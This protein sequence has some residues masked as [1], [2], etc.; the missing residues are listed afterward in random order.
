MGR[1]DLHMHSDISL[2]GEYTPKELAA[3]CGEHQI[4]VAALS[5]HNSV[6]GVPEMTEAC[7]ELGICVIPAV[8]LD[9]TCDGLDLHLLGYGI[10]TTDGRF[11]KNEQE[12]DRQS[13]A[14]SEYM[15]TALLD[16]GILFERGEVM[17]LARNGIVIGE[18]IAEAALADERNRDN[19]LLAPYR[20]GGERGRNPFVNF[21]WDF[22]SQGKPAFYP[23]HYPSF[24]DA[25]ELIRQTGGVPVLAHPAVTVGRRENMLSYMAEAGVEGI[26]VYSSYHQSEDILYYKKMAEKL[27]LF[28]TMGS[29]F[30]GKTKPSVLLGG[31]GAD[32][33][34]ENLLKALRERNLI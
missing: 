4:T 32:A 17:K 8:E 1:I 7:K 16:R 18:M 28:Q 10:D 5:D 20:P 2:D 29:D 15:M 11:G 3:M 21:Y 24:E 6:R 26:E 22:C 25:V 30:H 27:Q 23:I 33:C 12:I 13:R 14:A 19:P 34:E 9:C 31:T